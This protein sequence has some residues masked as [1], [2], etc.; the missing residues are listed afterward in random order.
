MPFV[1]ADDAGKHRV[2]PRAIRSLPPPLE[3]ILRRV[4]RAS[5]LGKKEREKTQRR[6]RDASDSAHR[7]GVQRLFIRI[8]GAIKGSR[9]RG[10]ERVEQRAPL[11]STHR[12]PRCSSRARTRGDSSGAITRMRACNA[13]LSRQDAG[14]GMAA[15]HLSAIYLWSRRRYRR[16]DGAS[17]ETANNRSRSLRM[18]TPPPRRSR[19]RAIIHA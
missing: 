19:R 5:E 8:P 9:D 18:F 15:A 16:I 12:P 3:I 1:S 13:D 4:H 2:I 14:R 10:G 7:V 17:A 11:T 6:M